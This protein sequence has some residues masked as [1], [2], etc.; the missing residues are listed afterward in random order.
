V[1]VADN[2]GRFEPGTGEMNYHQIAKALKNMG[3]RGPVG[4]ESFAQGDVETAL[5]AFRAAF[6]V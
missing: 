3:Y 5:E 1:Q 2:P 4:L 6:T